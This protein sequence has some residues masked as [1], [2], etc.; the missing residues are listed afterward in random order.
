MVIENMVTEDNRKRGKALNVF[1]D[2]E[3]TKFRSV[4]DEPKLISIGLVAEDG[5]LPLLD[6]S[7]RLQEA[8]FALKMSDW[9][10]SLGAGEVVLRCDSPS[11]DWT[12]VA[13]MFNFYGLWPAN[14]RRKCGTVYFE[15]DRQIH[16]YQAALSS[17]WKDNQSRMHHSL[18]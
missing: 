2:T 14:L 18:V 9:I 15:S 12:F 7:N 17:F 16:R 13:E 3:F 5:L 4:N 10:A 1:F 6:G 8:Q 11:Y